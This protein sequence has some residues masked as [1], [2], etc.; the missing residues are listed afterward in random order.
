M[1][2]AGGLPGV[3]PVRDSKVP[4]GPALCFQGA[5]WVAFIGDLKSRRP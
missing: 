2:V 4:Q 5:S 1:E 3:V